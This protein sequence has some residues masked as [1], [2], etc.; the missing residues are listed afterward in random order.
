MTF[1]MTTCSA[2]FRVL[3]IY[4]L[5]NKRNYYHDK[6][7]DSFVSDLQK[8]GRK[9]FSDPNKEE[10]QCTFSNNGVKTNLKKSFEEK[11]RMY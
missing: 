6:H 8:K 10:I 11:M 9:K 5:Q 1:Q 7:H 4:S 2:Q 3:L